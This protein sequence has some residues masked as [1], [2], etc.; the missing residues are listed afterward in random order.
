MFQVNNSFPHCGDHE[1]SIKEHKEG[2]FMVSTPGYEHLLSKGEK[3]PVK[4]MNF[5]FR[6]MDF[7][8][9]HPIYFT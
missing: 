3:L 2:C 7:T 9:H 4:G 5:P 8:L 1:E 6:R